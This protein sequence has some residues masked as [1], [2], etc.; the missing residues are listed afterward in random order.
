M[1]RDAVVVTVLG[2]AF[3]G[4]G[5]RR[6]QPAPISSPDGTMTLHSWI[7]QDRSDPKAYLCVVFQ[8]CD[9]AGQILKTENTLAS[10]RM[11]WDLTWDGND[12]VVLRSSD[13]GTYHWVRQ[14]DGRWERGEG[15]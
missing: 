4:C 10:D 2:L 13:I 14:A 15:D 11:R 8:V 9:R 3:A 6:T 5:T 7:E 1:L 12:R